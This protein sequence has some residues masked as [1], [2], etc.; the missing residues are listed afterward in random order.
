MNASTNG[1]HKKISSKSFSG[2]V[3]MVQCDI[4]HGD[5]G[6]ERYRTLLPLLLLHSILLQARWGS[7]LSAMMIFHL[8]NANPKASCKA[9]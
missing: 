7:R 8:P 1:E 5:G 3:H 9:S 4:L 2:M 6:N